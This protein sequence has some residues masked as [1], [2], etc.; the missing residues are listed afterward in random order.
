MKKKHVPELSLRSY[1][2][3]TLQVQVHSYFFYPKF[4]TNRPARRASKPNRVESSQASQPASRQPVTPA[5][6]RPAAGQPTN[7]PARQ[8]AC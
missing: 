8:P 7:Q 6:R 2:V 3:I 5:S 1:D 4:S